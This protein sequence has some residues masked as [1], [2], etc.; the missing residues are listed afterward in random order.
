LRRK[1]NTCDEHVPDRWPNR[2]RG[3][4]MSRNNVLYLV[5]GALAVVA[6]VLGYNLYQDRKEPKGLHINLD[7]KGLSIEKK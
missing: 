3:I 1:G 7:D 2:Q 4:P 6:V 5:I